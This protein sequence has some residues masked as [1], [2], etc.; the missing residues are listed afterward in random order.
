MEEKSQSHNNFTMKDN[1]YGL[2]VS[3]KTKMFGLK[4]CHNNKYSNIT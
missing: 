3:L 2:V 1:S 4:E